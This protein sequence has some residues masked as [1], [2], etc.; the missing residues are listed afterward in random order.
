VTTGRYEIRI[1]GRVSEETAFALDGLAVEVR[2]VETVLHGVITDQAALHGLLDRVADLGLEL[3][4]V[5]RLPE[6]P[7]DPG[8]ASAP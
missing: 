2:P 3:I 6:A 8:A 4:E 5:R 7:A 1:K